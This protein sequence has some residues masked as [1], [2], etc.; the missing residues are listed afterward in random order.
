LRRIYLNKWLGRRG[1]VL[2][3]QAF[4]KIGLSKERK[5]IKVKAFKFIQ[6]FLPPPLPKGV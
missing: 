6:V 5:A 1:V 2:K 4:N 3:K